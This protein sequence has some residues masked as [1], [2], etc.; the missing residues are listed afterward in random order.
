MPV[1]KDR[2]SKAQ[3]EINVYSE[4]KYSLIDYSSNSIDF[5]VCGVVEN[6]YKI[7]VFDVTISV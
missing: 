1:H 4:L 7:L 6:N 2:I 5:I 3:Q